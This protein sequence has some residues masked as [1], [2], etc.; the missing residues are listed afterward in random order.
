MSTPSGDNIW[1]WLI[2]ALLTGGGG[3]FLYD[4]VKDWKSQ[5]G[6]EQRHVATIDASIVTVARARD[7]LAEDNALIRATLAEERKHHDHERAIWNAEKVS[8]REE[9]EILRVQIRRE[10]DEAEQRY[11]SL[12]RRLAELSARHAPTEGTA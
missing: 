8:L 11:E 4:S 9:I 1:F 6:R 12:L 10:R 7:E 5:P 3:K 2:S